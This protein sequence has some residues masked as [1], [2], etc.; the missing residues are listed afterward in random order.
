M[1]M[2]NVLY[3]KLSPRSHI[4]WKSSLVD[5]P[6]TAPR[7]IHHATDSNPSESGADNEDFVPIIDN[8]KGVESDV[9]LMIPVIALRL[10][11]T[12]TCQVTMNPVIRNGETIQSSVRG[13]S[14]YTMSS[15]VR[16]IRK[17]SI[18]RETWM[19]DAMRLIDKLCDTFCCQKLQSFKHSNQGYM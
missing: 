12:K 16:Y 2:R 8:G 14:K 5:L 7:R 18:R 3:A 6:F 17:K 4:S 11:K 15:R 9:C 19:G 10:R 13:K 1:V